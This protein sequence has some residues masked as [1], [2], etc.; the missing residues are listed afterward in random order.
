MHQS[1]VPAFTELISQL[2]LRTGGDAIVPPLKGKPRATMKAQFK[3]KDNVGGVAWYRLTDIIRATIKY[4]TLEELYAG[5]KAIVKHLEDRKD[6][7]LPLELNDRY[8]HA[9]DG[10]Y[11]DL[12]MVAKFKGVIFELQLN[13]G[14][15]LVAKETTGHRDFEVV[16]ELQAAVKNGDLKQCDAA[17]E[18]GAFHLGTSESNGL[19]SL[20][21]NDSAK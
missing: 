6:C 2:A 16:R 4:G 11:R 9:M 3:Y 19:E 20:L 18:W 15:M 12:K 17:M 13:T 5:C 1:A 7:G 21:R 10:G 14:V 8:Q